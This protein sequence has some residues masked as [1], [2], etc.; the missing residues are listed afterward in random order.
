[1]PQEAVDRA[2]LTLEDLDDLVGQLVDVL[3]AFLGVAP[4]D[5]FP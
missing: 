3:G 2:A 5:E 1:V 4:G